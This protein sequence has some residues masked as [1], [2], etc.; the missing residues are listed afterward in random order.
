MYI[1]FD[2]SGKSVS[3]DQFEVRP[4]AQGMKL[5]RII[6]YILVVYCVENKVDTLYVQCALKPTRALCQSMGFELVPG[7]QSDFF[8]PLTD[9]NAR[10]LPEQCG[11]PAGLLRRD[12]IHPN[13]FRMDRS[14]FPTADQ[15]NDQEFVDARRVA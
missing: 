12:K 6:M 1:D 3:L 9:M 15:L 10:M 5:G 7:T 8:M 2:R 11:L 4:C 13:L 14:C